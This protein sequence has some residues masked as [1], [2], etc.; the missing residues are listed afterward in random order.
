[1]MK[2][3]ISCFL[4]VIIVSCQPKPMI[5]ATHQAPVDSVLFFQ[6]R[7][8]TDAFVAK[9]D[10]SVDEP[11]TLKVDRYPP[12]RLEP[13]P[14][15]FKEI[16][17]F[18]VQAFAGL[19]SL[20]VSKTAE[21]LQSIVLPDSIY[22][23]REHGLFKIHVGDYLYRPQADAM[24]TKLQQN[25]YPGAWVV[26]GTILIPAEPDSTAGRYKIQ[27]AATSTEANAQNVIEKAR[28]LT[29]FDLF[30]EKS[31]DL[32][33]VFIGFFKSE[34]DARDVLAKIRQAGFPDAWLVY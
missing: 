29:E 9:T 31:E 28:P 23:F 14:P 32:F 7:T 16:E 12:P 15:R 25:G 22:F 33:K 1:M 13:P 19:D 8:I 10:G 18:R 3:F 21:S 34:S 5:R 6:T 2:Y 24:R 27:I 11:I 4:I 30:Y 17:G 20:G 26:K